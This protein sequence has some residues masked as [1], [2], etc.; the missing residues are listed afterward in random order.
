MN[1]RRGWFTTGELAS[2]GVKPEASGAATSVVAQTRFGEKEEHGWLSSYGES[3][4]KITTEGGRHA[5]TCDVG[6][7]LREAFR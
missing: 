4:G 1:S 3:Q 5:L 2:A 6:C 7:R